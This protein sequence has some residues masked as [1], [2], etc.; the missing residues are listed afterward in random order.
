M[1]SFSPIVTA[2]T[3]KPG[4]Y[5]DPFQ[6][7]IVICGAMIENQFP[8]GSVYDNATK[9]R[10]KNLVQLSSLS[11]NRDKRLKIRN[12]NAKQPSGFQN[13]SPFGKN[14]RHLFPIEVF[15]CM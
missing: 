9:K 10:P 8:G 14:L 13:A 15:E 11:K 12:R 4:V 5:E 7:A 3:P 1:K 6:R 2:K